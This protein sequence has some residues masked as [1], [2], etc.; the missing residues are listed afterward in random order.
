MVKTKEAIVQSAVQLLSGSLPN[1]STPASLSSPVLA[2][3]LSFDYILA[4]ELATY[5]YYFSLTSYPLTVK[6]LPDEAK[7][8]LSED[9]QAAYYSLPPD[10]GE[11][12]C[13]VSQTFL[14]D[15]LSQAFFGK[16]KVQ[17]TVA[18]APVGQNL[19]LVQSLAE[20]LYL[21]Y[22]SVSPPIEN[23]SAPFINGL[24]YLIASDL[25]P[26]YK[27]LSSTRLSRIYSIKGRAA[28]R[29]AQSLDTR[30]S[31]KK[32]ENYTIDDYIERGGPDGRIGRGDWYGV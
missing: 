20:D 22:Y 1:I 16:N 18:F 27:E 12:L 4:T 3:S 32:E 10:S 17:N 7:Y 8:P 23:L 5:N 11:P 29:E 30:S 24:R 9:A 26:Q 31:S 2:G 13:I 25:A 19:I 21:L 28:I 6:E 15:A 14:T